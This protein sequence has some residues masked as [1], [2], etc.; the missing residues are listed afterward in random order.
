MAHHLRS[1][2]AITV[3]LCA[4]AGITVLANAHGVGYP[5]AV[6]VENGPYLISVWTDPDPLR[7]DEAHV[8][9]AVMDPETRAP[10]VENINVSVEMV[11]AADP[12]VVVTAHALPDNTANLLMYVVEFNDL[13]TTGTWDATVTVD[14]PWGEAS[15]VSFPLE[16]T[17]AR[18][19][20]WLWVGAAGLGVVVL[21]WLL[22]AS[23]KAPATDSPATKRRKRVP[24][25]G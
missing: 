21:L 23:R 15:D 12:S 10:L 13:V 9:V 1:A 25:S 8:V 16:I 11:N 18:G 14:G 19:F 2:V 3:T 6:N 22:F 7:E 4:L 17:P 5:Q 24:A 20:N